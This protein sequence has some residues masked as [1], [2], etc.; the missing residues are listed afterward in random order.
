MKKRKKKKHKKLILTVILIYIVVGVLI[1][2]ENAYSK[3][4]TQANGKVETNIAFYLVKADYQEQ[5]IKL[6]NLIPRPEPYV[7]NFTVTNTDNGK[8]SEVDT[9]YVLKIITTTNLPLRYELYMN[10]RY[11]DNESTNLIDDNNKEISRDEYGTYF[12]T[13][14]METQYLYYSKPKENNYTLLIYYDDENIDAKYQDTYESIKIIVE[15]QQML[16]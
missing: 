10:E 6:N 4:Q 5:H 16:D 3:Y 11:D 7:Y 9:S 13:I 14:T 2:I 12:Q 8:I 15:S 1:A